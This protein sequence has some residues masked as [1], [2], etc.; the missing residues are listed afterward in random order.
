MPED[1]RTH[2]EGQEDQGAPMRREIRPPRSRIN[3]RPVTDQRSDRRHLVC[4]SRA[5]KD[6]KSDLPDELKIDPGP[7]APIADSHA[8]PRL[9]PLAGKLP[10]RELTALKIVTA[11]AHR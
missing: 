1:R 2:D 3:G 10:V 9:Q 5:E 11:P 8:S 4:D 7:L 6:N